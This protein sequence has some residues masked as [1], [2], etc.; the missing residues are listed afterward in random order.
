VASYFRTIRQKYLLCG[1]LLL[2]L[3]IFF[4]SAPLLAQPVRWVLFFLAA[5]CAFTSLALLMAPT[6]A[7]APPVRQVLLD[8]HLSSIPRTLAEIYASMSPEQ[9]ELFSAALVMS[10]DGEYRF[11]AHSGQSG[12]QG[13]DSKLR[14]RRDQLVI[15][16]SKLYAQGNQ[17]GSSEMRNFAGSIP[18]HCAAYGYFVTTSTFSRDA[19]RVIA[20]FWQIR[21]IDGQ[22]I[23]ALLQHRHREIELA[24]NE[25]LSKI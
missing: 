11:V 12:D 25:V 13:V 5:F 20:A 6:R 1:L 21:P 22:Y 17:V 3:I 14:N 19:Q 8:D 18:L 10:L 9:F 15:V 4:V 24:Y 23:E 2:P 7:S 16:Q